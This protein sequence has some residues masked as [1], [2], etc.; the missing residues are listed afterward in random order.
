VVNLDAESG[1]AVHRLSDPEASRAD[2]PAATAPHAD[3][4]G[5]HRIRAHDHMAGWQGFP[6]I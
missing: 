3:A 5:K 6:R 4:G 1:L 2:G